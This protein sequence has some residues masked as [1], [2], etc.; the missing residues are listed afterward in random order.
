VI[1]LTYARHLPL[2][3]ADLFTALAARLLT[4][5]ATSPPPPSA[6]IS[7]DASV[8]LESVPLRTRAESAVPQ[9]TEHALLLQ[10]IARLK[11][12]TLA[13]GQTGG[14]GS[15]LQRQEEIAQRRRRIR[16]L[17]DELRALP[18][19]QREI[20]EL[21]D[22]IQQSVAEAEQRIDGTSR[23]D[24]GAVKYL[25]SQLSTLRDQY[26]GGQPNAHIVSAALGAALVLLERLGPSV[27][28]PQDV[29][30]LAAF[31]PSLTVR[32]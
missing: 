17:E 27:I 11:S 21:L 6:R 3:P 9:P 32:S 13:L 10:E 18:D 22:R 25:T 19:T 29:Q 30:A 1:A 8:T 23:V 14:A 16:E 26:A 31:G 5:R 20:L 7:G 4:L 2:D 15:P 28:N 12:E 24:P